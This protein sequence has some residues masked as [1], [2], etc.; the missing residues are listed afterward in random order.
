MSQPS[1]TAYKTDKKTLSLPLCSASNRTNHIR[2]RGT[3]SG[4]RDW[5]LTAGSPNQINPTPRLGG[6]GVQS[7]RKRVSAT[8]FSR[9]K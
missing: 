1:A 6:S 3:H 9:N 5:L 7:R 4:H 2:R 8:T